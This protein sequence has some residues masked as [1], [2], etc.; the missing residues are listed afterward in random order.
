MFLATKLQ[1]RDFV[2]LK[3]KQQREISFGDLAQLSLDKDL[4]AENSITN[5]TYFFLISY[6]FSIYLVGLLQSQYFDREKI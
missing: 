6:R 1:C 2:A 3:K 4:S 5:F